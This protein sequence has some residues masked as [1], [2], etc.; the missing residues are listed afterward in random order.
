MVVVVGGFVE[1]GKRIDLGGADVLR[2][3]EGGSDRQFNEELIVTST[4]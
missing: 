3:E 1:D 2:P 4:V